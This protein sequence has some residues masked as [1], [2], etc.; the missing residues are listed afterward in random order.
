MESV[1]TIRLATRSLLIASF[2]LAGCSTQPTQPSNPAE[3]P[4]ETV[5]KPTN[6]FPTLSRVE[7][8]LQCMQDHGGQNYDNLYHCTCAV[9]Y[10][11]GKMSHEDFDQA[12]AFTYLF[13]TPGERGAEFRDPPQ[14]DKLRSLLKKTK[15]EAAEQCFPT[16]PKAAQTK[17]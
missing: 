17:P 8:V 9:D 4:K 1:M 15:A 12:Q 3:T 11:A 13:N 6:D 5:A 10:I 7:Y 14:S 2:A 16:K